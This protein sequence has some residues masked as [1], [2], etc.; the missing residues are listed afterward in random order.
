MRRLLARED[1]HDGFSRGC[2]DSSLPVDP[3][4]LIPD[5][6][7]YQ[8]AGIHVLDVN[9]TQSGR[10]VAIQF[11]WGIECLR[12]ICRSGSCCVGI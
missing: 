5:Q 1:V 6:K 9:A 2:L 7:P 12:V 10:I 4:S 3:I 11:F 8:H